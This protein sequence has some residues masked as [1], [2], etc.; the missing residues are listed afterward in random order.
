MK[1]MIRANKGPE[2]VTGDYWK[3]FTDNIYKEFGFDLD[4]MSLE[5]PTQFLILYKDGKEYEAEVTK[6]FRG[7]YELLRDNIHYVGP[8]GN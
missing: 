1:R 7:P 5:E 6:Y 4:D 8:M 2:K 3:Q